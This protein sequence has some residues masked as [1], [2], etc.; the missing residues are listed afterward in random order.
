MRGTVKADAA[1]FGAGTDNETRNGLQITAPSYNMGAR[2]YTRFAGAPD[3]VFSKYDGADDYREDIWTRPYMA[4]WLSGGSIFN[5]ANPGLGVTLEL[6][7]ALHTD[8]GYTYG[9]TIYGSLGICT[10]SF[11]KGL[12]GEGHSRDISRDLTDM[13]LTGLRRDLAPAIGREWIYR[14]IWDKNYC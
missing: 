14:G 9:D 7:F 8:A 5:E 1:R 4:N 3:S 6:Y 11:N 12:L 13:V 10:T 2:Y